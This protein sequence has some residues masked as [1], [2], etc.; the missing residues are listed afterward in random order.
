MRK[1]YRKLYI[2]VFMDHFT[3]FVSLYPFVLSIVFTYP[4][5]P[6]YHHHHHNL[7]LLLILSFICFQDMAMSPESSV[8]QIRFKPRKRFV[9][10][11]FNFFF[12]CICY[13]LDP[14]SKDSMILSLKF[15]LSHCGI[16]IKYS[17]V[18]STYYTTMTDKVTISLKQYV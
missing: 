18:T 8:H 10:K 9:L 11:R 13:L 17:V 4:H 12:F 6:N 3:H 2:C 1:L 7:S 14:Y 15:Y 16:L 5:A